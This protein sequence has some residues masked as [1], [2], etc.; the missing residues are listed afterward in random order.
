DRIAFVGRIPY[1]DLPP[2]LAMMDVC[3]STQTDDIVGQ[4]R[5]TG[6]LP[7]YLASGRF[8]LASQVGEAARVLPP[9]MLAAYYGTRDSAYPRRLA[10][11]V[12]FILEH[13]ECLQQRAASVDLAKT[14]FDYDVLAA[15]LRQII[16][17]LLSSCANSHAEPLGLADVNPNAAGQC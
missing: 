2:Y 13:P 17:Q 12:R 3:L 11:R 6:K 15:R 14:H 4:V 1:D 7:L 8:V 16:R 5:T 9:E 10:D